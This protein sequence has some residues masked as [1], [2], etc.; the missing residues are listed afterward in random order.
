[1]SIAFST[2]L[3]CVLISINSIRRYKSP[4]CRSHNTD[5]SVYSN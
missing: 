5:S 2:H 4:I 3:H 1:M